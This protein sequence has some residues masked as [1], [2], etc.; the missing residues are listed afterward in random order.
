MKSLYEV[1]KD[2]KLIQDIVEIIQLFGYT[3]DVMVYCGDKITNE[4]NII[5]LGLVISRNKEVNSPWNAKI[6]LGA[7]LSALL[8]CQVDVI[9]LQAHSEPVADGILI[10]SASI[11]D[12]EMIREK[13]KVSSTKAIFLNDSE[14]P[15][16]DDVKR[17]DE[18]LATASQYLKKSSSAESL[19]K[20]AVVCEADLKK[21]KVD[22]SG[23]SDSPK[24]GS[25][26][27]PQKSNG[28][29]SK[30]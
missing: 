20:H 26:E 24:S 29:G 27:S 3:K 7:K 13:F 2:E 5:T 1:L 10:E 19:S 17:A 8:N 22:S 15:G 16:L 11:T 4:E 30:K 21:R 28:P 14:K 25:T 6:L 12:D 23:E 18:Y 9:S